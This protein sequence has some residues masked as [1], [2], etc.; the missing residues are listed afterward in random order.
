MKKNFYLFLLL[1][2]F[3]TNPL[4]STPFLKKKKVYSTALSLVALFS[5]VTILD[6]LFSKKK[7]DRD[8]KLLEKFYN[9][10]RDPNTLENI[11]LEDKKTREL[12]YYRDEILKDDEILPAFT[13]PFGIIYVKGDDRIKL[14]HD[15]YNEKEDVFLK[16][17][18]QNMHF[19]G[20]NKAGEPFLLKEKNREDGYF[21]HKMK[22]FSKEKPQKAFC[23]QDKY[24]LDR[25]G[26]TI[27]NLFSSYTKDSRTGDSPLANLCLEKFDIKNSRFDKPKCLSEK[28]M[29]YLKNNKVL[30]DQPRITGSHIPLQI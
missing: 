4:L 28:G 20:I 3:L 30:D 24:G 29:L 15:V 8:L 19:L 7:S 6:Y 5:T 27:Y 11:I 23:K 10:K 22:K 13:I 26:Y 17:N 16:E 9:R 25:I 14:L 1:F 2:H 18:V 12:F 21:R